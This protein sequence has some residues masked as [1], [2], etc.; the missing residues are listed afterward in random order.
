M[1]VVVAI[2]VG[3]FCRGRVPRFRKYR[4]AKFPSALLLN[5]SLN[6]T[7]SPSYSLPTRP[8]LS[9]FSV[10]YPSESPTS[11][12]LES[13]SGSHFA[14]SIIPL[15][16]HPISFSASLFSSPPTAYPLFTPSEF[17]WPPR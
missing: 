10:S 5:G 11:S 9:H 6:F 4:T 15:L 13:H 14:Y 16:Y 12:P 7:T 17:L 1:R 3:K 8:S 2:S